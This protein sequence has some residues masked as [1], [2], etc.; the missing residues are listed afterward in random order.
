M[1]SLGPQSR[2]P[3]NVFVSVNWEASASREVYTVTSVD[4]IN[5]SNMSAKIT[6]VIIEIPNKTS[7]TS[8]GR[9]EWIGHNGNSPGILHFALTRFKAASTNSPG[10]IFVSVFVGSLWVVP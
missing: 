5:G 1:Q 7:P 8:Y 9:S 2:G 6:D 4:L 10:S 3:D